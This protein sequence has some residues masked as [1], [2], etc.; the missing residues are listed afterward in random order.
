[1]AIFKRPIT[2]V[3][4]VLAKYANE[5]T[6]SCFPSYETIS[7]DAGI[8]N[9]QTISSALRV[10]EAFD[11][12]SIRHG[13]GRNVSNVYFLLQPSVWKVANS[14]MVDTVWKQRKSI[15][16]RGKRY[17]TNDT[18]S[19]TNDTGTLLRE[20][21]KEIEGDSLNANTNAPMKG[22][23]IEGSAGSASALSDESL[24]EEISL[25][26]HSLFDGYYSREQ[27]LCAA[28][29]AKSRG[30]DVDSRAVRAAFKRLELVPARPL[31]AWC[32]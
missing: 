15:S 26:A 6:Q 12:I 31:P 13:T 24:W 10:L 11:I 7:K 30:F 1:M 28:R 16:V 18:Y 14:V 32:S 27:I 17:Q 9:R 21:T 3:Y 4:C 20:S 29:D 8:K 25:A 19:G 23:V 5:K 22:V 2:Q